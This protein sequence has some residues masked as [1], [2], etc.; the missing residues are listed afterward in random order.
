MA[1]TKVKSGLID[2]SFGTDWNSTI[3]TSDFTAVNGAGYFV[4]TTSGGITVTLPAGV[5]GEEIIIQD[6]ART[7]DT[8]VLTLTANGSEKIQASTSDFVC[9]TA[10]ARITLLYQSATQGWTSQDINQITPISGINFLVIAGGGGSSQDNAGGVGGGGYRNSY[11]SETSGGGGSAETALT[12]NTY[13]PYTVTI[14]AGGAGTTG[15]TSANGNDSVLST[16]TSLGG[17]GGGTRNGSTA[18]GT[19]GSGGGGGSTTGAGATAGAGTA[20]Q[21]YEGGAGDYA[22]S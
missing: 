5:V 22:R 10:N 14:G 7:F 6:Y 21:G 11:N 20:N 18:A 3:Q 2:A 16:I 1:Q 13:T 9:S 4:D 12:L 17:G 15:Y 8:N 19:G